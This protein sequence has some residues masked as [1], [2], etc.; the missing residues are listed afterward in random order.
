[1][2][3]RGHGCCIAVLLACCLPAQAA[4]SDNWFLAASR[5]GPGAFTQ[6]ANWILTGA[7]EIAAQT[8][9]ATSANYVL[10]G[11]FG[12]MTDV[13]VAGRP[14]ITGVSPGRAGLLGGTALTVHGTELHLL[15]GASLTI[16]NA[17]AP[18]VSGTTAAFQT[19]LPAQSQPGPRPVSLSS[20]FGVTFLPAGVGVLPMLEWK[21]P[22]QEMVP[23]DLIYRGRPGDLFLVILGFGPGPFPIPFAP[24]HYGLGIDPGVFL[25]SGV[26][27]VGDPAGSVTLPLPALAGIS[28]MYFQAAALTTDPTYAVGS[29][30]NVVSIQ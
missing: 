28:G 3:P 5:E 9:P 4:S 24:L 23:F 6:S 30:S 7:I 1:M 20:G 8:A 29:F 11:G 12:A 19:V 21:A 17:P 15:G 27:G 16:G 26:I 13:P 25:T 22:P 10:T 18:I 2:A 14:W